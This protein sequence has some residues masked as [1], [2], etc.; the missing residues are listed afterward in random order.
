MGGGGMGREMRMEYRRRGGGFVDSGGGYGNDNDN[1]GKGGS[2]QILA[3]AVRDRLVKFWTCCK[4]GGWKGKG[5]G[6]SNGPGLWKCRATLNSRNLWENK[7]HYDNGCGS[8]K[9]VRIRKRRRRK[10]ESTTRRRTDTPPQI[11]ALMFV[12]Y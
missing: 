11:H 3:S 1:L 4:E 6:E 12:D 2:Y 8:A 7:V 5:K 10:E 9:R